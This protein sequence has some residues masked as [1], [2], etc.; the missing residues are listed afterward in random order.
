MRKAV[1]SL[2]LILSAG[3]AQAQNLS[4]LII[5][6]AMYGCD[7]SITDDYGRHCDWVEL[8]NTSQG[9]VNF[10]G[11]FLTDDLSDL[12]KCQITKDDRSTTLG[13]RQVKVLYAAGD[14][15]LGSYYLNFTL[16]R[17]GVIYLV[18]NDGRT[19]IDSLAIPA[20]LPEGKSISKFAHDNKELV[21]TD[22][23]PSD[24]SPRSLN[25][26]HNQKSRAQIM[27]E[28]DPHGWTLTIIS[29][30]V[31][32]CALLILFLIYR[33]SGNIFTGKYKL[34]K[35]RSA[36]DSDTA[37]AIALALDLWSGSDDTAAAIALALHL[38]SSD[39]VHD[40]EPGIITIKPRTGSNWG[41]KSLS[42]RKT[43]Q[44]HENI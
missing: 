31:V 6:E 17:G 9:T 12:R 18:G 21:F 39:G 38:Y 22:I 7:S 23:R 10:A 33:L 15:S 40:I 11:C 1:I 29:V 28:T 24:P 37:A 43:P 19:V 14:S 27:K 42:F 16:P 44:K 36:A 30:S 13:P 25:G 2:I 41:N 20:D 35:K 26:K 8:F 4:D 32:F 3:F 34:R 5:S